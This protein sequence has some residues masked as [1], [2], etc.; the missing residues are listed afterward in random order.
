[1][2]PLPS[3]TSENS[4]VETPLPKNHETPATLQEEICTSTPEDIKPQ[5]TEEKPLVTEDLSLPKIE[6]TSEDEFEAKPFTGQ[7]F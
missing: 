7:L 6:L 1:M 2:S 3:F 5:P 4:P